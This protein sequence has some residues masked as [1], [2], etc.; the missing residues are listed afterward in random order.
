[1]ALFLKEICTNGKCFIGGT[2]IY[3]SHGYKV[4]KEIKELS[5]II[6]IYIAGGG[7]AVNV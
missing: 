1:M 3:T 6:I 4:I 5:D 2:L 7:M